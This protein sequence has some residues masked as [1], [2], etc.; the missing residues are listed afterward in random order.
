M[1]QSRKSFKQIQNFYSIKTEI[2]TNYLWFLSQNYQAAHFEGCGG[3]HS[4]TLQ[5]MI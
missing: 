3:Q 4:C 2:I 5:H 1:R